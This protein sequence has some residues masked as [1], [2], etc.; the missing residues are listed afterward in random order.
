MRSLR[1]TSLIAT[2]AALLLALGACKGDSSKGNPDVLAQDSS[3]TRDLQLANHDSTAQPQLKDVATTPPPAPPK[4]ETVA[5][6]RAT[7]EPKPAPRHVEIARSTPRRAP[8]VEQPAPT[9][10]PTPAPV[11]TASGNTVT[12]GPASSGKS[13]GKVGV[14][15]AGTSLALQAGQRVCTNTNAVGDRITATLTDAV[16]ASNGV[17]IPAGATAILEITSLQRSGGSGEKMDIGL[18][19]KSITYEGKTYPID[20]EITYAQTDQVRAADNN[21]AAKVGGGAV[22]GAILGN[23]LGGRNKTKGTIIGAAG[24]A[25]AGAVLAHQTAKYDACIPSGGRVTVRLDAPMSVQQSTI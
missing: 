9:R 21:D 5:P 1:S 14:V 24:G 12:T 18:V 20:G 19:A 22:V 17:I 7:P 13:E 8:V 16:T 15:S 10:A 25:A 11:T 3:L 6:Q 4:T 2:S 23:I